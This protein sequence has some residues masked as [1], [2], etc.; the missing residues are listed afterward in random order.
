MAKNN[1]TKV[2]DK[3]KEELNP[4]LDGVRK[5]LLA[6]VGV[7]SLAQEEMEDFVNRL[8]ERGEIAEKDA[9]QL[10][11]DVLEKR[12]KHAKKVEE[13][14]DRR[15]DDLLDRLNIPTRADIEELNAKIAALTKK[16][17]ELK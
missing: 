7:V 8:V 9:R 16:I 1:G 13:E 6:G 17:D 11:D 5:V 3:V 2:T 15:F 4:I 12:K 14:L 10:L